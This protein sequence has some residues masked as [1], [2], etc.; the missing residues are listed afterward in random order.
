M[1]LF[2][3]L[4]GLR[5]VTLIAAP[6]GYGKTTLVESWLQTVDLP[7]AWLTLDERHREPARFAA[8]L[9][10]ALHALP[11]IDVETLLSGS[12]SAQ[13]L[14]DNLPPLLH[15]LPAPTILVLDGYHTLE[16][17]ETHGLISRIVQHPPCNLHLVL[18]TR[19]NPPLALA[20]LRA[21]G[22]LTEVRT[23]ALRFTAAETVALLAQMPDVPINDATIAR[24]LDATEGWITGML[25]AAPHLRDQAEIGAALARMQ[26]GNSHILEYLT[27]EVLYQEP[28]EV[29]EFLIKT[30]ILDRLHPALCAAL[31]DAT[32]KQQDYLRIL[33]EDNLFV[34]EIEGSDGWLRYARL[35]QQG[36]IVHLHQHYPPDDIARLHRRASAWFAEA[37]MID[38]ALRH[39]LA[40]DDTAHAIQLVALRR[41]DL[42]NSE[43]WETLQRWLTYFH[44][45]TITDSAE[46]MLAEAWLLL[47]QDRI[48]EFAP[49]LTRI[50]RLLTTEATVAPVA[51][52]RAEAEAL[53]CHYLLVTMRLQAVITQAGMTVAALP[54]SWRLARSFVLFSHAAAL[55]MTG[56]LAQANAVLN[57]ALIWPQSYPSIFH[58]RVLAA[59][60]QVLWVAG[61]LPAMLRAARQVLLLSEQLHLAQMQRWGAYYVGSV[62]YLWDELEQAVAVLEPVVREPVASHAIAFANASCVLAATYQAQG[63]NAEASAVLRSASDFL[64][65]NNRT[66]QPMIQAFAA[67]LALRQQNAGRAAQLVI[68]QPTIGQDAPAFHFLAPQLVR[69]KVLL[70][71]DQPAARQEAAALLATAQTFFAETHNT[72]FLIET[73]ALLAIVYDA[74]NRR[75]D[76][77]AALA[78]ALG[79]AQPGGLVRV[80]VDIGAGLLPLL[81]ALAAHADAP[82]LTNQIRT[83]IKR[84]I[85]AAS[86]PSTAPSPSTPPTV[87]SNRAGAPASASPSIA[88]NNA[89]LVEPL[90]ARELDV[91]AAMA[92]HLTSR[93]IADRLGISAHTIKHHIGNI[94]GKLEVTNRRQAVARARS[95]GLLPTDPHH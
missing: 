35:F 11:S 31:L 60:C 15:A 65:I 57:D 29:Q 22:L 4:A 91:L 48:Q 74:E 70:A 68:Q 72:R 38:D 56:D 3:L 28:A 83:A 66:Y 84:E 87:E 6:A 45:T 78:T 50:D 41:H 2:A 14:P 7:R 79:L 63:R 33:S 90:T 88:S 81:D 94:L 59:Q 77:V 49:L 46:L 71:L 24:L 44:R 17:S 64:R 40:A 75:V 34:H 55:Q 27:V 61:D 23:N 76:A 85:R 86:S 93:E 39:A 89:G 13:A 36:L 10:A 8:D 1:R 16:R 58:V 9:A 12:G 53:R 52:L 95:L 54:V 62:Y 30:S 32:D 26:H 21:H 43:E 37:G 92:Q 19:R 51:Q 18:V 73:L 42:M 25:L 80:F 20:S 47:N 82:P 69:P 67:E 5:P